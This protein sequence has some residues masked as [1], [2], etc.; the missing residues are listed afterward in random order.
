MRHT[1][2]ATVVLVFMATT[3]ATATDRVSVYGLKAV[4]VDQGLAVSLQEQLESSLTMYGTFEVLSRTDMDLILAE[5]RF[6]QSGACTDESCLVE[7]SSLLGIDK[8]ITGTVSRIGSSYN[9]V[10][11][12]I[13]VQSARVE[14]A[15]NGRHAGPPDGLLD[16]GETLLVRLL[17]SREPLQQP[18]PVV[19]TV[20]R[21]VVRTQYDTVRVRD[22]V[23]MSV[24]QPEPPAPEPQYQQPPEL[25]AAEKKR[26][27]RIGVGALVALCGVAATILTASIVE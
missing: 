2:T 1:L 12:L 15:A 21:T 7:A 4:G 22:T 3:G 20:V 26:Y 9:L 23:M 13:D 24:L 11:K 5:G 8:L 10:L 27:R 14:S 17:T 6:Q 25:T 16:V 18:E 19:D